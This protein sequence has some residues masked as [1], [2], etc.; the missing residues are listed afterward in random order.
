MLVAERY[1]FER[2]DRFARFIHRL[3]RVLETLRGNDRAKLTIAINYYPD[4]PCNSDA[5]DARDKGPTVSCCRADAD[6]SEFVN[7]SPTFD[8]DVITARSVTYTGFMSY[9]DVVAAGGVGIE[10]RIADGRVVAAGGVH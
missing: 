8:V 9:R 6:G 2:Q 10:R 4:T 5:T 7:S 3:N 1:R